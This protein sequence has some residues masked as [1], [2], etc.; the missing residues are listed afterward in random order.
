[1]IY[2]NDIP[3]LRDPESFEYVPDDRVEKIELMNGVGIQDFGHVE[4]GDVFIVE[5]VFL[6]D[7]LSEIL[8]LWEAREKVSF[9][10]TAGITWQGLRIVMK[11]L[12]RDPHFPKYIIAN[13]ELW[14]K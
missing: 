8:A 3:S 11:S 4:E 6:D 1:M 13:F 7:N 2:I 9:T 12:R 14:R 5:C 10:D